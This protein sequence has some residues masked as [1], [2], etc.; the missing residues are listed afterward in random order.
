MAPYADLPIPPEAHERLTVL[1]ALLREW[2]AKLNLVSRQDVDNLESRHL[3][4]CLAPLRFLKL[5]PGATLLDVGTGGGLPG[6]PLA[7]CYP[8]AKF[9]L[10]DSTGK[11]IRAV[12]DMA[13][14]LGLV[15]VEAR[16]AR[17]ET[18][19]GGFD[20]V[21]G[22]AVAALPEFLTW[23]HKLLRPGARHSLVNGLLLWKGGDLAAEIHAL[24][25]QPRQRFFLEALL[26]DEYFREKY[27]LHFAAEDF[28]RKKKPEAG[29]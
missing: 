7:I 12:E 13:Q 2:N 29:S 16:Q 5:E 17:V 26:H 28:M 19:T 22:R 1:A 9:L 24:G 27:I 6:L 4:S 11:K 8:Q 25:R 18:L 3:A 14:R 15:N 20:F 21:L 23:T 10:V